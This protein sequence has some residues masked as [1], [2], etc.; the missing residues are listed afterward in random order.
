M[1][2]FYYKEL[3][4]NNDIVSVVLSGRL[5]TE[6]C[7]YLL[8]CVQK[9]IENGCN[10]LILDCDGLEYISSMGLGMLMRVHSRM[11]KHG[12]DT[13]LACVHGIVAEA[14]K[15]VRLDKLLEMYPSVEQAM[16]AHGG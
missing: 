5:D 9:Q 16:A 6:Q 7:D 13:K 3:G 15:L 4:I 10:K 8:H 14:I 12:G 11:L 2:D 1:A